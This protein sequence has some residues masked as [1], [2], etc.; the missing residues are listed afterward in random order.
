M[1]ETSQPGETSQPRDPHETGEH[2]DSCDN[3]DH[4]DNIDCREC[5]LRPESIP[6]EKS[7]KSLVAHDNEK[8]LLWRMTM[9]RAPI[10]LETK[11]G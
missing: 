3:T 7:K 11:R 5:L 4:Y 1:C 2:S 9:K 10:I 8:N 6:S